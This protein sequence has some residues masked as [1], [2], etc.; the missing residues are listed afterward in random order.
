M[1]KLISM[2]STFHK[3]YE[4]HHEPP[5][6][7]IM[8]LLCRTKRSVFLDSRIGMS[9]AFDFR[10]KIVV[11]TGG[12]TG[13]G[14]AIVDEMVKAGAIVHNIDLVAPD[15]FNKEPFEVFHCC[16]VAKP[17]R[18][19]KCFDVIGENIDVLVTNAGV[20]SAASVV[21]ASEE[22]F[23]RLVGINV[24]GAFFAIQNA[25]PLMK[26]RGGSI[27]VIG[28]DQSFVGKG[29]QNLYGLT[30][31][32]L[33]Q[34]AKSCAAQFAS[35]NVRV[36]CVCPGTIDT[37]LMH[38]AVREFSKKMNKEPSELYEWL[39]TA[40]PIPRLGQPEEVA[41]MVLSVCC[42]SFMTGAMIAVDGGYTAV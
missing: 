38:G 19:K 24:K 42:N 4:S 32:A 25:F 11:I 5:F 33:A 36:N 39:N 23:D 27:V 10:D 16:D 13:I 15:Q 7:D 31:G 17:E 28:S 21:D 12:S 20:W 30:K 8:L 29:D 1:E 9:S 22:D 3:L 41:Q 18:L 37:P 34:L 26:E 2:N 6:L 35:L 14:R 40:Q